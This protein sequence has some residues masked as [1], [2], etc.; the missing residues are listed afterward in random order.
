MGKEERK[1][2]KKKSDALIFA[3]YRLPPGAIAGEKRRKRMG[4][5][6]KKK[7]GKKPLS[8]RPLAPRRRGKGKVSERRESRSASL[9]FFSKK[10]RKGKKK[11]LG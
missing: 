4:S 5:L 7:K 1:G 10:G 9:P 6:R 11:G 2:E 8:M 3:F